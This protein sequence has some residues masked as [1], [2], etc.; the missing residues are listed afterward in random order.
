[1]SAVELFQREMCHLFLDFDFAKVY[2]DDMLTHT[3]GNEKDHVNTISTA[4]ERLQ[5]HNLK[6]KASKYEFL[7]QK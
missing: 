3:N 1:M 7:K 5:Q 6:V 4:M 2:L